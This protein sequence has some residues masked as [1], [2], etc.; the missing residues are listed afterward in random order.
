M[1]TAQKK[2]K[3]KQNKT[4]R[5]VSVIFSLGIYKGINNNNK[6]INKV[7]CNTWVDTQET[8]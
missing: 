7:A 2:D 6:L 1:L 8:K 3:N 4:K 5:H